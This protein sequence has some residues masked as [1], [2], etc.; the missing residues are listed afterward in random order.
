M[1]ALSTMLSMCE[2]HTL[3]TRTFS[4]ASMTI[5]TLETNYFEP[6]PSCCACSNTSDC[7]WKLTTLCPF[8]HQAQILLSRLRKSFFMPELL[9]IRLSYTP[10][11][12]HF[13]TKESIY[14]SHGSQLVCSAIFLR[15]P[16]HKQPRPYETNQLNKSSSSRHKRRQGRL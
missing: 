12:L 4:V 3:R 16:P 1:V 7:F 15:A 14:K 5:A 11:K 6:S 13:F 2:Q 9:V 8:P 10:E